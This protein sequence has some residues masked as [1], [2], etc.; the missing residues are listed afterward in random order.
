M[1]ISRSFDDHGKATALMLIKIDSQPP[2]TL[3]EK[4]RARPNI[5]RVKSVVLPVRN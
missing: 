1:V 4:L 3:V 2:A 5:L